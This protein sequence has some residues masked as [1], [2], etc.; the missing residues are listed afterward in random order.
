MLSLLSDLIDETP[1]GKS[2]QRVSELILISAC[3]GV[4]RSPKSAPNLIL[5]CRNSTVAPSAL[6]SSNCTWRAGLEI[7]SNPKRHRFHHS[8]QRA[9]FHDRHSRILHYQITA[10]ICLS[11]VLFAASDYVSF[12]AQRMSKVAAAVEHF[13][14][15]PSFDLL[16]KNWSEIGGKS[17][18]SEIR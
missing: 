16:P 7:S 8:Q 4:V 15:N 18:R 1:F 14:G 2:K 11:E 9:L 6:P 3:Q 13:L 12:L 10:I 17:R 5:G